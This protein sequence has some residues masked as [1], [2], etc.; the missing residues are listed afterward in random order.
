MFRKYR[1]LPRP[2]WMG[3]FMVP[4]VAAFFLLRFVNPTGSGVLYVSTAIVGTSVGAISAIAIPISSEMFGMKSFGVNHN[5]LVT[6]I[7]FGSLLFG[8]VAGI[9]YDDSSSSSGMDKHLRDSADWHLCMGRRCFEKT[10]LVWGCVCLF[11]IVLCIVLCMRTREL[12]ESIHK[13]Q[14]HETDQG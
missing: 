11:G 2:G 9:I 13:K 4:M 5:I 3:I 6:N 10:F 1:P 8:E 14:C 12:Y 7:A